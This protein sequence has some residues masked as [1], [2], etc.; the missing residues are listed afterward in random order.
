[1]VDEE[2]GDGD[3]DDY[4]DLADHDADDGVDD[5]DTDDYVAAEEGAVVTGKYQNAC[6]VDNVDGVCAFK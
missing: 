3:G 5:A 2:D 1:M 4:D 6:D